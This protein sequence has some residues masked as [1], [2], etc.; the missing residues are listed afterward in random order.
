MFFTTVKLQTKLKDIEW[1]DTS[2]P[3]SIDDQNSLIRLHRI[4]FKFWLCFLSHSR[5]VKLTYPSGYLNLN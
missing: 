3:K 2:H 4:E 5:Q 1:N